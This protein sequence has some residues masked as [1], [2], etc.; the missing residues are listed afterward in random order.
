MS[1]KFGTRASG[2]PFDTAVIQAVWEKAV[3]VPGI[4]PAKIRRDAC[5]AW[6]E[7][8]QYEITVGNGTGWEIDHIRPV[9]QGGTE[10]LGN[11]QALQWENNRRKGDQYPDWECARA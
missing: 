6:I 8:H 10:D 4:D 1:R 2:A 5:G 3:I 9:A 11:L 7:R